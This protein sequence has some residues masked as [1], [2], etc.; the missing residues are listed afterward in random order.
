MIIL[1]IY[2]T[3]KYFDPFLACEEEAPRYLSITQHFSE[4]LCRRRVNDLRYA[5]FHY[6]G[7]SSSRLYKARICAESS[8]GATLRWRS[9]IEGLESVLSSL[10]SRSTHEGSH[11]SHARFTCCVK[12][13]VAS[14]S[15][16]SPAAVDGAPFSS[17][18]DIRLLMLRIPLAPQG[19]LICQV[20]IFHTAS[21]EA[22][23]KGWCH[24]GHSHE[25]KR[26]N[27]YQITE[28]DLTVST[29]SYVLPCVQSVEVSSPEM[30]FLVS[31]V[32]EAA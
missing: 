2:R 27:S 11:G 9:T 8:I 5:V 10:K 22:F 21:G 3:Q 31:A 19:D 30:Y 18:R 24:W 4:C 16:N 20:S 1:Y 28:A 25:G 14:S 15:D 6:S 13:T 26:Y 29:L 32:C 23:I 17:A 7:F 12:E